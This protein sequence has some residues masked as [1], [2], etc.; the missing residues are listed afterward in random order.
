MQAKNVACLLAEHLDNKPNLR[1]AD[2]T[3]AK[4]SGVEKVVLHGCVHC[5]QH[6][7][8]PNDKKVNCPL[9]VK[10]R[11]KIGSTSTANEVV[12]YY[13]P[14]RKRLEVLLRL[15]NFLYLLQVHV[16]C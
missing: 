11:Y 1:E 9:C 2:R 3:L 4:Q 12:F 13:F 14:L 6:V 8:G 15:P 10:S 16:E 5:D 7:Y